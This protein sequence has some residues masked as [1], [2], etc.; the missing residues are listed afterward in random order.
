MRAGMRVSAALGAM[1]T[2]W[3]RSWGLESLAQGAKRADAS[4][5]LIT[6]VG[7]SLVGTHGEVRWREQRRARS[8][9][10][11]TVTRAT[12]AVTHD[13]RARSEALQ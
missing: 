3:P 2:R 5:S 12:L 10:G 13:A 9:P 1:V 7:G 6:W 8:M 11:A 4:G